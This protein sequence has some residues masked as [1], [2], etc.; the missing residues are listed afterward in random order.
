MKSDETDRGLWAV[1]IDIT[2]SIPWPDQ[3]QTYFLKKSLC[4]AV[5]FKLLAIGLEICLMAK[6]ANLNN[7]NAPTT[8]AGRIVWP[9]TTSCTLRWKCPLDDVFDPSLCAMRTFCCNC[10]NLCHPDIGKTRFLERGGWLAG[11]APSKFFEQVNNKLKY[12]INTIPSTGLS[13]LKKIL[14]FFS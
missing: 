10:C 7:G 2:V 4:L 5:V 12:K 8:M 3:T 11:Y 9:F 6:L 1:T 13:R 14:L